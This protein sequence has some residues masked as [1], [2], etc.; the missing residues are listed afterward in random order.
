MGLFSQ[1]FNGTTKIMTIPETMTTFDVKTAYSAWKIWV[2]EGDNAKYLPAFKTVGGDPTIG[3]NYI[4]TYYF[5]TNDWKIKPPEKN[6]T[7]QVNG[8]LLVDGGGDPF[9]S[10]QG[11]YNV[12]I[13]MTT[14]M[15]A[16]SIIVETGVSGLTTAEST[17]LMA[18]PA[19]PLLATDARLDKYATKSDLGVL[20]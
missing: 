20:L 13:N 17:R 14:P 19:N 15:Q 6:C 4:S 16:E 1:Y 10:T 5:L 18:I 9:V 3:G 8:I 2:T 12:R 11:T 7:I